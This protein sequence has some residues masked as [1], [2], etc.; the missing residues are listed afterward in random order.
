MKHTIVGSSSVVS[1]AVVARIYAFD[2][3]AFWWQVELGDQLVIS[4]AHVTFSIHAQQNKQLSKARLL[5]RHAPCRFWA[6]SLK[7]LW[8]S[9]WALPTEQETRNSRE[10]YL[11]YIAHTLLLLGAFSGFQSGI[12]ARMLL[13]MRHAE[14]AR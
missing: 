2:G 6:H 1:Q 10:T 3:R 13:P 8:R 12:F 7:N 4:V 9:S 11:P 5:R 14:H